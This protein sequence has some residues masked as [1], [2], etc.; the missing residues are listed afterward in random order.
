[1]FV[2]HFIKRKILRLFFPNSSKVWVSFVV[3]VIKELYV[4]DEIFF[5]MKRSYMFMRESIQLGITLHGFFLIIIFFEFPVCRQL[6]LSSFNFLKLFGN[7]TT[8]L[9]HETLF[10]EYFDFYHSVK[11]K[12]GIIQKASVTCTYDFTS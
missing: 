5:F 11:C 1:M 7:L 2:I 6:C 3:H 8:E 10:F 4:F 9:S 12:C